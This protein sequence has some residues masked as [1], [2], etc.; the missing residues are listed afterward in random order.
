MI[1]RGCRDCSSRRD[2][3]IC[4]TG[5]STDGETITKVTGHNSI[6]HREDLLAFAQRDW[7]AVERSKREFWAERFR[8]EGS[9]AARHASRLLLEHARA[10]PGR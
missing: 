3:T 9:A 10:L 5:L 8:R 4:R 6:M 2:G 7:A 1:S